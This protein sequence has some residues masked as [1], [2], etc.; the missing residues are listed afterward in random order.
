MVKPYAFDEH[1]KL[2]VQS[3]VRHQA[4]NNKANRTEKWNTLRRHICALFLYLP[5]SARVAVY[6][7]VCESVH[8][9]NRRI[10]RCLM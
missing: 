4:Q 6:V 10:T 5:P 7:C 3:R 1:T 8:S 9:M 2:H